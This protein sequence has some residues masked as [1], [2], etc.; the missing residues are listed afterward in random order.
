GTIMTTLLR[1]VVTLLAVSTVAL[2]S[3]GAR[4]EETDAR[5]GAATPETLWNTVG[6]A[7]C[8]GDDE[9]YR[10]RIKGALGKPT[11]AVARWIRDA[12]SVKRDTLMP[13]FKS[14]LGEPES[15]ALAQWVLSR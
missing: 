3:S 2:R 10:D 1:S 15:R 9:Y 8:H 13:S 5:P 14:T 11:D 6:C 12:P 7:A 4:A